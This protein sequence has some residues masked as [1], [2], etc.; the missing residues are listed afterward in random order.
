MPV[1]MTYFTP[2]MVMEVSAILV[3][4]MTLRKPYEMNKKRMHISYMHVCGVCMYFIACMCVCVCVCVLCVCDVCMYVHVVVH[5]I[6]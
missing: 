5:L 3:D 4:K 2:G 1:S 6:K